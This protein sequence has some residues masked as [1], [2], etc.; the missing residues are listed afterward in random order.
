[1]S[2]LGN[3]ACQDQLDQ[4]K[5]FLETQKQQQQM[6]DL[7]T[8]QNNKMQEE[9]RNVQN[10]WNNQKNNKQKVGISDC[11]TVGEN[12]QNVCQKYDL[13]YWGDYNG[14]GFLNAGV[15]PICKH[16]DSWYDAQMQQSIN[17]I[18]TKYNISNMPPSITPI[19][20]DFNCQVCNQN[21][22]ICNVLTGQDKADCVI[23]GISQSQTCIMDKSS[24]T[25]STTIKPITQQLTQTPIPQPMNKNFFI[26][27][28]IFGIFMFLLILILIL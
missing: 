20:F 15:N 5:G 14:C 28:G 25:N 13:D 12:R 3:N 11:I 17:S 6:F 24:S 27:F 2:T 9:I 10:D 1:M 26:I 18:K 4:F 19:N 23:K 21:M 7:W 16:K 8:T 22:N